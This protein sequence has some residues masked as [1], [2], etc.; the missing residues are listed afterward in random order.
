MDGSVKNYGRIGTKCFGT[1]QFGQTLW[2][3]GSW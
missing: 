1:K 3:T 2:K